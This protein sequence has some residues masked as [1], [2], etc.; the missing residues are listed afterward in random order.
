MVIARY[1]QAKIEVVTELTEEMGYFAIPNADENGA[2]I[3]TTATGFYK[4]YAPLDFVYRGGLLVVDGMEITS[5]A[6]D[7][8]TSLYAAKILLKADSEIVLKY[9]DRSGEIKNVY[10]GLYIVSDPAT[11]LSNGSAE[12]VEYNSGDA[13]TFV[14]D[15]NGTYKIS[16]TGSTNTWF[17][18]QLNGSQ[19]AYLDSEPYEFTVEITDY[20]V[21]YITIIVDWTDTATINVTLN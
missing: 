7:A 14:F 5:F 4:I 17:D 16:I 15:A 13:L 19:I 10:F 20:T 9:N 12:Y 2:V 8:T 1:E 18:C 11:T 3:T 6:Y 21:D